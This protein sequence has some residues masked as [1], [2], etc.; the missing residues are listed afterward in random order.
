MARGGRAGGWPRLLP[1]SAL[2]SAPR[3]APPRGA[4]RPQAALTP[5]RAPLP[6]ARRPLFAQLRVALYLPKAVTAEAVRDLLTGPPFDLARQYGQALSYAAIVF[7]F[8]PAMPLLYP[9]GAAAFFLLYCTDKAMLLRVTRIPP[10]YDE[11]LSEEL[12]PAFKLIVRAVV[13][14]RLRLCLWLLLPFG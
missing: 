1:R 11:E 2:P 5:L 10:A 8:G 6:P 9:M 12:Q 14:L 13:L 4:A 7:I 3:P